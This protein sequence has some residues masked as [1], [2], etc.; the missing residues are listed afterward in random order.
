VEYPSTAEI[1]SDLHEIE[2]QITKGLAELE[3]LLD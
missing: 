3:T 1:M 2:M